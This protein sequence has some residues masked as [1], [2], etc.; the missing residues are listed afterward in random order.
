M[1]NINIT[2]VDLGSVLLK[3]SP[4]EFRED[5]LIVA[6]TTT[7]VEGT[8]LARDS[9]SLKLVAYIKGGVTNEN[10]IPK[11]VLTYDVANA[12][13]APVD[14]AVRVPA[15]ASVRKQRLVIDADGD[16]TNIDAAVIDQLRD[17][18]ITP[19]NADDKSVL[20]NQ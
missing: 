5:T 11:T 3:A 8:I 10:G 19:I 2:N 13:G 4:L 7:L 20:D 6:A 1:A 15:L 9:V 16:D 17:Y 12:T 14:N 18:G